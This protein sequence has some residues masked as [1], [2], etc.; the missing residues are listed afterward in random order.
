MDGLCGCLK[1]YFGVFSIKYPFREIKSLVMPAALRGF[2]L[3]YVFSVTKKC[4][5]MLKLILI[6]T[7][8]NLLW[9][10]LTVCN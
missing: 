4:Q 8:R 5:K 7:K 2:I 3:T 9:N 10:Y 6:F 1:L